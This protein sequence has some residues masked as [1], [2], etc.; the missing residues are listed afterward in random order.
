MVPLHGN[1][2]EFAATSSSMKTAPTRTHGLSIF[3]PCTHS[4]WQA[5]IPALLGTDEPCGLGVISRSRWKGFSGSC[6][7]TCIGVKSF[8]LRDHRNLAENDGLLHEDPDASETPQRDRSMRQ[9]HR[10]EHMFRD[11][12]SLEGVPY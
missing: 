5:A 11:E 7:N 1:A 3:S 10:A 8:Q 4:K 6:R 9:R 12:I 2:I